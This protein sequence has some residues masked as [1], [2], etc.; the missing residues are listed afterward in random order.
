MQLSVLIAT[1]DHTTSAIYQRLLA[2]CGHEVETVSGG[3]E[4]LTKLRE[5][6]PDLLVLDGE[7]PWGGADGVL[8]WMR[9]DEHAIFAIPVV[10]VATDAA[11]ERSFQ[12]T[13]PPVVCCLR[14][15]FRP[16]TLL[17]AVCVAGQQARE[18]SRN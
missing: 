18:T 15:P 13:T 14:K 12:S 11:A 1:A 2:A 16:S 17:E 5:L 3:L 4:C 7:L 10:L 8:A 9:E 6:V